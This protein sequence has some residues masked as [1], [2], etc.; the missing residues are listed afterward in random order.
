MDWTPEFIQAIVA[1]IIAIVTAIAA[2]VQ[3]LKKN[4]A[5]AQTATTVAALTSGTSESKDPAVIAALPERTWKMSDATKHWCIVDA[6]TANAAT[7]LAQIDAAE[8]QKLTHYQV[9]FDGGYYIIDYGLLMGGAGNP[10]GK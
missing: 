1:G 5:V 7:I 2:L 6:T 10:S 3:T 8:A 4:T 9:S